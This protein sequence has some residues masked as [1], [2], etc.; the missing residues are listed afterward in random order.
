MINYDWVRW[1]FQIIPEGDRVEEPSEKDYDL[2]CKGLSIL[3]DALKDADVKDPERKWKFVKM[4]DEA[5]MFQ[6]GSKRIYWWIDPEQALLI[7]GGIDAVKFNEWCKKEYDRIVS[8]VGGG[9]NGTD[10]PVEHGS[11]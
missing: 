11:S 4:S 1:L 9:S 5:E 7:S 3:R 2:I 6:I 8:S 10:E